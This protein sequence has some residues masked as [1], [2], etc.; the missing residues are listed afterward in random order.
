MGRIRRAVGK[1][2]CAKRRNLRG[3]SPRPATRVAPPPSFFA[4]E[5]VVNLPKQL[6]FKRFFKARAM[7]LLRFEYLNDIITF[8]VSDLTLLFFSAKLATILVL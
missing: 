5:K 2:V 7:L 8:V 1:A 6:S 4:D 3:R